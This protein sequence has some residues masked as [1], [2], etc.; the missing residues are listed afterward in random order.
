MVDVVICSTSPALKTIKKKLTAA[1]P[2]LIIVG[3]E[4]LFDFN[5]DVN[6]S[7]SCE[8]PKQGVGFSNA[9]AGCLILEEF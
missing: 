6:R 4:Q 7:S 8:A 5:S 2:K 3:N 1:L 9:A